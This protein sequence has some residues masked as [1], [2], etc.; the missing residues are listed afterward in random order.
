MRDN[1]PV[2]VEDDGEIRV[3][4]WQFDAWGGRFGSDVPYEL[5]NLVPQRVAAYLGMPLMT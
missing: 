5:D 2:F 1:G 4:N 3:Q